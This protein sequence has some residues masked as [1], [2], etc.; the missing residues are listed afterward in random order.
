MN[1]HE[2]Y[3]GSYENNIFFTEG[4]IKEHY[5]VLERLKKTSMR[6]NSNLKKIKESL[7]YDAAM[8]GADA[9]IHFKYGQKKSLFTL[10]DNTKWVVEGTVIKLNRN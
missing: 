9:V 8:M 5:T 6:Q 3:R 10:W 2:K 7:A 4:D 1:L